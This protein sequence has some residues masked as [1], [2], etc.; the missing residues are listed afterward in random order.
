MET[1]DKDLMDPIYENTS[2]DLSEDIS[3]KSRRLQRA[4]KKF[5]RGI[6][7]VLLHYEHIR[8]LQRSKLVG[9]KAS[10]NKI[11]NAMKESTDITR[12][13]IKLQYDFES[14]LN[15]FLN[16]KILLLYINSQGEL[17]YSG[18]TEAKKIY[19]TAMKTEGGKGSIKRL[20]QD[21][22]KKMKNYPKEISEE[23]H[24]MLR[25]RESVYRPITDEVIKRWTDNHN[26]NN[27]WVQED[28]SRKDTFY[29]LVGLSGTKKIW[30][31][32]SIINRGNIYEAYSNLIWEN[33]KEED[34][35]PEK[36]EDIKKFWN[37][38][39]NHNLL[40]SVSGI[41]KG[42]ITFFK[43]PSIQLAVK[44]GSFNTAAIGSYIDVAYELAYGN[45]VLETGGGKG[46]RIISKDKIEILLNNL[47]SF[48]RALSKYGLETA[49][50]KLFSIIKESLI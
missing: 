12:E 50:E 13:C 31:W 33:E 15:L 23:F 21:T 36:E 40:N 14:S 16:R 46:K 28:K 30:D 8:V 26:D 45:F 6:R 9:T 4:A 7:N 37:Y 49:E 35:S 25:H 32:S 19:Q 5:L 39:E 48:S 10:L 17:L 34:F 27:I 18:E 43:D 42:D 38:M 3:I 44:S 2:K 47:A 29:W 11:Y 22:E 1:V 41:V 24:K 20:S